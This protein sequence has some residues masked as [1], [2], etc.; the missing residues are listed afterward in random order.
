MD[1]NRLIA[2]GGKSGSGKTTLVSALIECFPTAYER[3]K[4]CTTRL[5]RNGENDEEYNF[6]SH[7][8]FV[9]LSE[10]GEFLNIDYVYGNYYAIK[11]Q[12]VA[13]VIARG[14]IPIK[15]IHPQNHTKIRELFNGTVLSILVKSA[16]TLSANIERSEQDTAYYDG[17]NEDEFDI[18]FFYDT[19]LSPEK[20]AY[21][22]HQKIHTA[23]AY[24]GVF[25]P[26]GIIDALNRIRKSSK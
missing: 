3:P 10:R 26:A 18:V 2:I 25:P 15:E 7:S 19:N 17:I 4:S 8:E 5:K 13:D 24:E 11:T 1:K 6:I 22:F 21:Y 23:L 12:S 9:H 14:K 16:I 20:N